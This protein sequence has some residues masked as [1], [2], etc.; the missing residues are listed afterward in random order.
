[1]DA[2]HVA[3]NAPLLFKK[4]ARPLFFDRLALS[5]PLVASYVPEEMLFTC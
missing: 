5:L 1:M 3:I 4:L 2:E